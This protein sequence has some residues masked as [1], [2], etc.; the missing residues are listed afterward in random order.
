MNSFMPIVYIL[1]HLLSNTLTVLKL[2]LAIAVVSKNSKQYHAAWQN[3]QE[4]SFS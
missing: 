1:F 2:A 3:N 4:Q